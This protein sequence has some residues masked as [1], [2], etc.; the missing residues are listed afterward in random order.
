MVVHSPLAKETPLYAMP[1]FAA[2]KASFQ[3]D[4]V[5]PDH[6]DYEAAIKRWANNASRRAM[7]VAF[8]KNP[9]D[10]SLAISYARESGLPLA[11]RGGG[12]NPA[13]SSSSEGIVIDLSRYLNECRVDADNKLAYVGGGT[14]WKTVDETAIKYG[15]ATVGGTVNHV[16]IFFLSLFM[17]SPLMFPPSTRLA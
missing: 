6:P 2:F 10:V 1:S 4:I 14:L 17:I 8:V 11:I 15:L 7:I 13:G 3:G 12:H 5:T 16:R 9:T